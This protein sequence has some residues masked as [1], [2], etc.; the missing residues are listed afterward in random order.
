MTN[1]KLNQYPIEIQNE[2]KDTLGAYGRCS[3][4]RENG[5]YSVSTGIMLK[6]DYAPDHKVEYFNADEVLTPT[7]K[8]LAYANNFHS[9]PQEY[10]GEHDYLAMKQARENRSKI[11]LDENGN[12]VY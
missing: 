8:M 10:K 12:F 6:T 2:V 1:T 4:I 9:F 7:E 3:V 5:K 11:T